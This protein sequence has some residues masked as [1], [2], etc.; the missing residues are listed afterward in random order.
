[1]SSGISCTCSESWYLIR[2]AELIPSVFPPRREVTPYTREQYILVMGKG[3]NH[4]KLSL[5]PRSRARR[6]RT[7]CPISNETGWIFVAL[8]CDRIDFSW[9]RETDF[10]TYLCIFSKSFWSISISRTCSER[11]WWMKVEL[12]VEYS[13]G[14][15]RRSERRAWIHVIN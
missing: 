1:M 10:W 5:G 12:I 8:L 3:P 2:R 6:T 9:R 15:M 13:E 11:A 7:K 4:R 14:I